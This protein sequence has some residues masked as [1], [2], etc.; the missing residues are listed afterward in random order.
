MDVLHLTTNIISHT[1][2]SLLQMYLETAENT[3]VH[4]LMIVV[5]TAAMPYSVCSGSKV[6]QLRLSG[7]VFI[8]ALDKTADF[9]Q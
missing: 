1:A 2:T 6:H 8:C 7:Y 9:V 5:P 3:L 4:H